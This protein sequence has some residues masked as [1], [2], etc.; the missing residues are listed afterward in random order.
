MD[1]NIGNIISTGSRR[2]RKH[3]GIIGLLPSD[4]EKAIEY[5]RNEEAELLEMVRKARNEW[6]DAST[7]FEH[8]NEEELVD[9]FTYK[10]KACES[11]YA[12]FLRKAKEQG[13]KAAISEDAEKGSCS[14][15][16]R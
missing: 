13:I 8:V 6:L 12:F 4:T 15:I 14:D 2:N 10:M 5:Q 3:N 9:Y 7:S 16:L 1:I 11:R